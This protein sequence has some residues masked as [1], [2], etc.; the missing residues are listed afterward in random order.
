M[1]SDTRNGNRTHADAFREDG[2]LRA[3]FAAMS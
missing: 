1:L 3:S 2:L